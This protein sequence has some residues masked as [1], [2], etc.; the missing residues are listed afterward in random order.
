MI[1]GKVGEN[2][3]SMDVYH[4]LSP[5]IGFGIAMSSFDSRFLIE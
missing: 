1:F 3:F 5:C 4:P 2:T